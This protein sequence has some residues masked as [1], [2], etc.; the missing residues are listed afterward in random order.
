MEFWQ[1]YTGT[2]LGMIGRLLGGEDWKLESYVEM[3][4]PET[5]TEDTRSPEQIKED[6]IARLTA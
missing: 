4:Y 2:A 3:A 5:S 6:I 1:S